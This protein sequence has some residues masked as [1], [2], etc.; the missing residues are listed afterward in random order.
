MPVHIKCTLLFPAEFSAPEQLQSV[1]AGDETGQQQRGSPHPGKMSAGEDYLKETGVFD[2]LTDVLFSVLEEEPTDAVDV[3]PRA[4]PPCCSLSVVV[5]L[6]AP[7]M[8][9]RPPPRRKSP[10]R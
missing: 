7:M 2:H 3:R 8:D 5:A 1:R 10:P 9:R 6:L 4:K